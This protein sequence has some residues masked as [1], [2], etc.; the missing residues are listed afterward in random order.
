M[1]TGRGNVQPEHNHEPQPTSA[2]DIYAWCSQ[3]GSVDHAGDYPLSAPCAC[4]TA[5]AIKTTPSEPWRHR[6]DADVT[7]EPA[8][9]EG[10][11]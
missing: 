5:W 4:G 6:T 11:R 10:H 1:K 3:R 9:R 2:E 8:D 7:D